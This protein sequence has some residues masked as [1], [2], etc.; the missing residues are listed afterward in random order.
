[1]RVWVY[2]FSW[3]TPVV[4]GMLGACHALEVP[5]VFETL[6]DAAVLVGDDPPV[7]LAA[8]VHGAWTGFGRSGDP[9]ARWPPY[10]IER[11]PVMDFGSRIAVVDDPERE[12]RE[13]WR[14][15]V[16]AWVYQ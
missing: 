9:G 11:R 14:D 7:E 10:D 1:A 6:G 3:P 5:F 13:L 4:G 12:R 16:G 2:R 8:A 15:L